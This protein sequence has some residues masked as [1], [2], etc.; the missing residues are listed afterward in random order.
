MPA[1][2]LAFVQFINPGHEHAP[3]AGEIKT[4]NR[5]PHRRKFLL[6]D[7]TYL[8]DG[9]RRQG[10]VAFWGAPEPPSRIVAR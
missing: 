4:W 6:A 9:E 7:G 5:G 10:R 2:A 1:D 8:L 3:D